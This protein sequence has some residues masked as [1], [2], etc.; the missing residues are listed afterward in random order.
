MRLLEVHNEITRVFMGLPR[1]W[2][3]VCSARQSS[4][5]LLLFHRVKILRRISGQFFSKHFKRSCI[6]WF[7]YRSAVAQ[8]MGHFYLEKRRYSCPFTIS[9]FLEI[10]GF[11]GKLN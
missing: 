5:L 11:F 10:C 7:V 9:H 2:S 8:L 3:L 6:Y 1:R 4:A